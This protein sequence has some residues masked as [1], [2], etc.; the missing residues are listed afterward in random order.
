MEKIYSKVVEGKLL[1]FLIRRNDF[2]DGRVD[3][4]NSDQF[5]QCAMLKHDKGKTF[6][7][8]QHIWNEWSG[9]KISQECWVVIKGWVKVLY[10]DVNGTFLQ[11]YVLGAGDATF[12]LEGGHT[13]EILE[14]DSRIL[15]F[16]TGPYE[17]QAKDK[18]FL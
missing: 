6:P 10:F 13:Y 18:V 14:S 11:S 3:L 16:K 5:L 7:A 15:E 9:K 1:H 4:I 2:A 8:H 17:G 12:T